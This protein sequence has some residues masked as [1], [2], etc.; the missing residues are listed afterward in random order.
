LSCAIQ[1]DEQV[2]D[3]SKSTNS[4]VA[5]ATPQTTTATTTQKQDPCC[6]VKI[7]G[8]VQ[9]SYN[10]LSRSNRFISG[11][12]DRSFD[13]AEDG[14]T[15][16]QAA[17]TLSYQP[18]TGW[19]GLFNAVLGRDALSIA[20]FGYDPNIGADNIGFTPVQVYAEYTRG[21]FNLMLGNFN[22]LVGL[23]ATDPTNNT[24]FS[25]SNPATFSQP[26]T[27]LG[28]RAN[29][30]VNDKLKLMVGLN[31]G[32][33]DIR[34]TARD[35]TIELGLTYTPNTKFSF[36]IDGLSGEQRVVDKTAFGP[37]GTR[38]LLDMYGTYNVT[39]KF[40]LSANIDIGTQGN[41]TLQ[42]GTIGKANWLGMAGYINY[43]FND[44]WRV[45]LRGD[46]FNDRNGYRTGV[47]QNLKELTLSIGY[48]PIK[49]LNI[50]AET[51]RDFSNVD[52]FV[53]INSTN[54]GDTQ[55]S[56]ALVALYSFSNS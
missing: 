26:N 1:A 18:T 36:N 19:G 6:G 31:N 45:S 17:V 25:L 39:D 9:E 11:V 41:A 3:Q 35:R 51:R 37:I 15:L 21:S 13:L 55:Q 5:T 24:N 54:V 8:Y 22:S 10:H 27:V 28:A 2:I 4:T 33:D 43:K 48:V 56:F 29:Y 49:N 40:S 32:W 46:D 16:Q 7:S 23:E 52:A 20:P 42:D 44:T 12:F 30:T 38:N 34:D 53:D 14:T 47:A 50:C